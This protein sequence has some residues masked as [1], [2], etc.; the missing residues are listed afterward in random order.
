MGQGLGSQCCMVGSASVWGDDMLL[1]MMLV[2][3]EKAIGLCV[4]GG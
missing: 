4:L 2:Q 1:D 3:Q